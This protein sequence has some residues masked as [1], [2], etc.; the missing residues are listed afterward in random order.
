MLN[1][2]LLAGMKNR[3]TQRSVYRDIKIVT[4][5]PLGRA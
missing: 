1:F 2:T 3:T 4:R 5:K